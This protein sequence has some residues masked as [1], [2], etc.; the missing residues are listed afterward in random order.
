MKPVIYLAAPFGHPDEIIRN[1]RFAQVNQYAVQ[2]IQAG[3]LV[4]SPLTH[5]VTLASFGLKNGWDYWQSFDCA[6]LF[7]CDKLLLLQL[8]GWQD[9]KGVQ[10]ELAFAEQQNIPI[11]YIQPESPVCAMAV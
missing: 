1:Q 8:E 2:L 4:Y 11:E 7:R 5:N 9:S 3:H 10:A 6:M